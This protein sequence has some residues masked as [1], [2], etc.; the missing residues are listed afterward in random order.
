MC[1]SITESQDIEDNEAENYGA[2]TI[3]IKACFIGGATSIPSA[4]PRNVPR[5]RNEHIRIVIYQI[6]KINKQITTNYGTLSLVL[7]V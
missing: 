5:N 6:D 2:L 1:Y 4:A 7:H 3:R